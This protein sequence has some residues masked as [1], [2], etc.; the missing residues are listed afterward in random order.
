MLIGSK[1]LQLRCKYDNKSGVTSERDVHR[2]LQKLDHGL[3][4]P[5]SYIQ[6]PVT[7]V[8]ENGDPVI[9]LVNWPILQIGQ[10]DIDQ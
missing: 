1:R 2:R 9:S 4:I 7:V 10:L 8:N 3:Q 6:L 5:I